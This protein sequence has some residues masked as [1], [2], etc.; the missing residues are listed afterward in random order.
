MQGGPACGS[1][2]RVSENHSLAV[3]GVAL[4]GAGLRGLTVGSQVLCCLLRPSRPAEDRS[5][6]TWG[7]SKAEAAGHGAQPQGLPPGP[8]V[9]QAGWAALPS[10][11]GRAGV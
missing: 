9:G 8:R 10:L 7:L 3:Q 11:Q 4:E 6:A 2:G 1:L 5:G